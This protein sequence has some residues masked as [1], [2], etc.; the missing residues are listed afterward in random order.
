MG[1]AALRQLLLDT[2]VWLWYVEGSKRLRPRSRKLLED[3]S[4]VCWLSPIS[5]LELAALV[6]KQR[7][8][9]ASTTGRWLEDAL[10][11]FPISDAAFDRKVGLE[12]AGRRLPHPDPADRILVATAIAYDLELVTADERLLK[13]D[14][15]STVPV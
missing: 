9:L 8:K 6:E 2:H 15:L 4:S 7:V 12:L 14:W 3:D 5:L 13:L 11:R 10:N 1:V